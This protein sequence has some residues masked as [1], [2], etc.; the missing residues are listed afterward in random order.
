[1]I[2]VW[3]PATTGNPLVSLYS[4]ALHALLHCP[5]AGSLRSVWFPPM[6]S[7]PYA[8]VDKLIYIADL[9]LAERNLDG[10]ANERHIDEE[11]LPL[12]TLLVVLARGDEGA[13]LRLKEAFT[14]DNM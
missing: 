3:Q 11:L 2:L 13:K 5:L 4:H 1:M 6:A 12:L 7:H 14:P 9:T 10:G 8:I